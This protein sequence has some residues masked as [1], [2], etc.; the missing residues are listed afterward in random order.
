MPWRRRLH[1]YNCPESIFSHYTLH[2]ESGQGT[3]TVHGGILILHAC[4][5]VEHDNNPKEDM[6]WEMAHLTIGSEGKVTNSQLIGN[7][8]R[9]LKK[10]QMV[11]RSKPL[12]FPDFM[13]ATENHVDHVEVRLRTKHLRIKQV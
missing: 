12:A 4:A 7:S 11:R 2:S 8:F 10:F 5:Q 1:V 13:L 3:V 6:S 9:Y